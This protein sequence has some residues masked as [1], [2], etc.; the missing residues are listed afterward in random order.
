MEYKIIGDSCCDYTKEM[1]QDPA[2]CII[3]LTL[4]I[5]DY[6]VID[7]DHFDQIDFLKRVA[8]SPVGPKTACPSPEAYKDAIEASDASEVYI[9]TLSEHLS[10]SYQSACIGLQMYEEDCPDETRKKVHVFG[11][12][13]ASAGQCNICLRIKELKEQG[14]DFEHVVKEIDD[15][16]YRMQTYFVLENL[17]TLRKNGRLS[18]VKSL[19]VSALNIKPVMGAIHGV[20]I[21]KDRQ[22]GMNR[23]LKKM[24]EIAVAEAGGPE[25]TRDLRVVITHVNC[26][27]RAEFVKEELMRT[28]PFRDIVITDAMG[29]A[30]VYA[31]D[32]GIVI[33]L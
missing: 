9:V 21:Q 12:D 22:R 28:A 30:T 23:A 32:G 1:K 14:L 17:D 5:G 29:V 24:V 27:E 7:D 4:E 33:A 31:C 8:A 18:A 20:I 26:P 16:I 10:G 2:Y 6:T 25:K 11:S 3:P 13:S 15:M 19:L